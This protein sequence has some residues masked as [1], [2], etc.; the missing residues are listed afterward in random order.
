[1]QGFAHLSLTMYSELYKLLSKSED[2]EPCI[3]GGNY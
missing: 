2:F 1:M 3:F